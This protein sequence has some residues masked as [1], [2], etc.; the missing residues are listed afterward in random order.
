MWRTMAK[1]SSGRAQ[2]KSMIAHS[3]ATDVTINSPG[4]KKAAK[5]ED[6]WDNIIMDKL[7]YKSS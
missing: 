1:K 3:C 7:R 5:V 2:L 6:L 4:M